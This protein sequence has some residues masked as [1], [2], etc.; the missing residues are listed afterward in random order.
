MESLS[1]DY[2]P[3]SWLIEDFV[4][5]RRSHHT[6]VWTGSEMIIWGGEFSYSELA[7]GGRYRPSLD[8]WEPITDTGEPSARSYHT[9]VWSGTEM[10]IWGGYSNTGGRYNP[11]TD[12][13]QA[14]STASP[15][16]SSRWGHTAVWTGTSMII[17][18]G[19]SSINT[20]GIYNP[21][22]DSWT[23]TSTGTNCPSGRNLHTA[24]WSGSDMIVWGGD[25][26]TNTGGRYNPFSNTWAATSTGTNCPSARY[27][28][29][30]VWA[31]DRMIVWGGGYNPSTASGGCYFPGTN[32]WT[33]TSTGTNCPTARRNHTAVWTGERMVIWGGI[34]AWD[35]LVNTGGSYY[36]FGPSPNTWTAT[37]TATNCPSARQ[38]HTAV[39]TGTEMVVW[40][41]SG[42][43]DSVLATGGRYSA[44]SDSWVPAATT[45]NAGASSIW[46]TSVW[47]GAEFI[48]WG[49]RL[50]GLDASH[51]GPAASTGWTF[52]PASA[53]WRAITTSNCPSTRDNHTAVW[54][55]TEMIVWGGWDSASNY[56]NT[57]GRYNPLTDNWLP[58]STGANC[59]SARN[60]HTAVWTGS[61][62]IIWGGW[63]NSG[64]KY[65]PS[66]DSWEATSTG[67]NCPSSRAYHSAVWTG[68]E[69]VIWGGHDGSSVTVTGG[70][71]NPTSNTWLATSTDVGG[72]IPRWGHIA[73]WTGA[74]MIVWGGQSS[75]GFTWYC[76]GAHYDPTANSWEPMPSWQ[77]PP[78]YWQGVVWSGSDLL[79]WGGHDG[80]L[81]L[82]KGD[83]RLLTFPSGSWRLMASPRFPIGSS[84]P[85]VNWTGKSM[86]TWGGW[87]S[88]E[89]LA[90]Y[91][92]N[93]PPTSSPYI[94][95]IDD[96]LVL[97]GSSTL[98]LSH[99]LPTSWWDQVEGDQNWTC[100]PA[101][102]E[103]QWHIVNGET[104]SGW[105]DYTSAARAWRFGNSSGCDYTREKGVEDP[106]TFTLTS[107]STFDISDRTMLAFRYFLATDAAK[108][109]TAKVEISNNGGGSWVT[110]A[111]DDSHNSA[112]IPPR[113]YSMEDDCVSWR[114]CAIRL[115]DFISQIP[116]GSNILVR[117]SF[118]R[119]WTGDGTLGWLIDDIGVGEPAGDGSNPCP[120]DPTGTL[121]CTEGAIPYHDTW[122]RAS[123]GWDL[124]G[125]GIADNPD[126]ATP[127]WN[128]GEDELIGLYGRDGVLGD[129]LITLKV[130]D[131]LYLSDQSPALTLHILD[132]RP[133]SAV[134]LQPNGGESWE[135]S[136]GDSSPVTH[137]IYWDSSDD[138]GISR[139]KLSYT[140]KQNPGEGDWTCIADTKVPGGD[141]AADLLT[142]SSTS[143]LWT[144]PT[145]EQAAGSTPP[146][147]FPSAH[148]KVRIQVWDRS[149]NLAADSSDGTFYIVQPTSTSVK[150]LILTNTDRIGSPGEI[151]GKLVELA[152][153]DNVD[154][155]VLDLKNV[156]SLSDPSTGLYALWD[157]DSP[158]T[159][160]NATLANAVA[161]GIR[162]YVKQQV[163]NTYKNAKYLVIAGDDHVIPFY[164]VDDGT[165]TFPEGSQY[166]SAVDC[167][168]PLGRAICSN[169]YLTDNTFGDMDYENTGSVGMGFL[170]LPDL[171][172]GRLVQN[173]QEIIDTCNTFISQD[174]QAD[175]NKALVTAYD[176]LT[177][178]AVHIKGSYTDAGQTVHDHIGGTWSSADLE[179]DLFPTPS[180]DRFAVHNLNDHSD[181]HAF[182]TPSGVL[183]AATMDLHTGRPLE[184]SV[185]YNV[186]CHSGL[187]VPDTWA[188]GKYPLDLPQ[189]MMRKGV[190]AYVGNTG[191]GWG[192]KNG[193]GYS[194]R[195]MELITEQL[196]SGNP[197]LGRALTA[198]KREYFLENHR[199]DVFDEKALLQSTLYGL[200]MYEVVVGSYLARKPEKLLSA[201]GPDVQ[202]EGG[203]RMTKSTRS[204][205]TDGDLPPG[206][207]E[208]TM[209][210][211]FGPLTY[212]R[213]E[214]GE[215]S[216]YTY[217]GRSNGEVGDTIQPNFIFDSRLADTVNH[218][219]L[220][221]GGRFSTEGFDPVVG[222]VQSSNTPTNEGPI[223]PGMK[224][225]IGSV[226]RT[227]LPANSAL[228]A[229]ANN[230][231]LTRLTVYNGVFDSGKESIFS[232]MGF[233]MYYSNNGSDYAPP[234]ITDPAPGTPH[235]MNGMTANF[236][237]VAEDTGSDVYRV[238]V[239]Y[240][241]ITGLAQG[242]WKSFDL[243]QNSGVWEGSLTLKR[244][245]S[246][247]IQAVDKAGNCG[248]MEMTG[249]DL[250]KNG[251]PYGSQYMSAK[252][253]TITLQDSDSDGMPDDWEVP[254]GLNP[255]L[256]DA[257]GDPD[258][259]LLTNIQ[260]FN[261]DTDPQ[262]GDTDNDGDNDGSEKNNG[263]N[264]LVD[265]DG[266]VI[267]LL[268]HRQGIDAVL[269]WLPATGNNAAIDGPYWVYRS[270]S[271]DFLPSDALA[272][273]PLTDPA[274]SFTDTT[275]IGTPLYFYTVR[276]VPYTL[277][278]MVDTVSPSS[279]PSAGGTSLK[280]YGENFKSGAT[281]KIGGNLCTN[282]VVVSDIKI[283]C[284]SPVGTPGPKNVVVTNPDGKSGTKAG[285]FVYY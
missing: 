215:G 47:T 49:G 182:G 242:E 223:A 159:D 218:G 170:A 249:Q 60:G 206:V 213:E 230:N 210:F 227:T 7:D 24:V 141:C 221:T 167:D 207:T 45:A 73:V 195:L 276:N 243:A 110:V 106:D 149:E 103:G 59:P 252:F 235:E 115:K 232:N 240:T 137:W 144:M 22:T 266:K 233:V 155:V 10:I 185:F 34:D 17:W 15:C 238:L 53:L 66:A 87:N 119:D 174:G 28:H 261:A 200:P 108:G 201:D 179:A 222:V 138:F 126:S 16:P 273:M 99:T 133:P 260:E 97:T 168:T 259:D 268:A 265:G 214:T 283:T 162:S 229:E 2:K 228:R 264:P 158:V 246:Y 145:L 36:P 197:A 178:S 120:F 71:Y 79:F 163:E 46:C 64:G 142:T 153:N 202:E 32:T 80:Y 203:T 219:V 244:D 263:R 44:F 180:T 85:L 169:H 208:L 189:L 190:A 4:M 212:S 113:P 104:C 57:G 38:S 253:Y 69:M 125:D 40:G 161:D 109:D 55:G 183:E 25:P 146:Q 193:I 134:I 245:I 281:V 56:Y 19:W 184:G 65:T 282:V 107:G 90:F 129:H 18:G 89:M 114:A 279:G 93:T 198:A 181:H 247:F 72:L 209:N 280:V 256:N 26:E 111:I 226:T 285:G 241:E 100:Y 68:T 98:N 191:F 96:T 3:D 257:A 122:D 172:T 35:T 196:L 173:P 271:H 204:A 225:M 136:P 101:C 117:F 76:D 224:S 95:N 132:G 217:N 61:K 41:G 171:A 151:Y 248:F 77:N 121:N 160:A 51:P 75:D 9:A 42:E 63:S 255:S 177:D 192:L 140:T 154:G 270:T 165:A 236:S 275:A 139:I 216:Y 31:G 164:R 82:P 116:I 37:S 86:L 1:G 11:G 186:G 237:V 135:Y 91:Y 43:N 278:P 29:T 88:F 30:A 118:T 112:G 176:F 152:V 33:T 84:G 188:S 156:P 83:G 199:Y 70:R 23:A 258:Q 6:A 211:E 131:S 48:V 81:E 251:Q 166:A 67:S 128:I 272:G 105:V 143:F 52:N 13:W 175:F 92:P 12:S 194:E 205:E 269:E 94:L 58:T 277:S 50:Y 148:A 250:D 284:T 14:T 20:G 150:T 239:A 262:N 21:F 267:S 187:N 274:T 254:H 62:M 234:A 127:V 157:A 78:S 130:T 231:I 8:A 147:T 39:W 123:F 5:K 74:K 102:G 124:T 27:G 54:T 220:F